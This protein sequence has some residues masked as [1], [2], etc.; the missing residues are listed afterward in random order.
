MPQ[1]GIMHLGQRRLFSYLVVACLCASAACQKSYDSVTLRLPEN[2]DN[3]YAQGILKKDWKS[4]EKLSEQNPDAFVQLIHLQSL[5]EQ[6]KFADVLKLPT[7]EDKRFKSYSVYLRNLAARELKNWEV[8]I[9]S[10]TPNDLPESLQEKIIFMK[11]T[12]YEAVDRPDEGKKIYATMIQNFPRG[13]L[14]SDALNHLAAIESKSENLSKALSYYEELYTTY[15]FHSEDHLT[16]QILIQNGRLATISI[17][18][19]LQRVTQLKKS[20]LFPRARREIEFIRRTILSPNDSSALQKLQLA[21]AQVQFSDKK[22]SLVE[23]ISRAA[24]KTPLNL[25][26]E[27]E[28]RQ[29][30]ASALIRQDKGE[31]GIAEYEKL[32]QK[33][34]APSLRE[35]I[36]YRMGMSH[37]DDGFYD[38]ASD[39]F[40]E[41]RDMPSST[42]Y[43][44]SAHWFG[45]WSLIQ[46]LK[47]KPDQ[48]A[49]RTEA[50]TLLSR[51]PHLPD[52][53]PFTPQALFWESVM[54]TDPVLK[55]QKLEELRDHWP[56]SFY[57]QLAKAKP[58]HFLSLNFDIK[59]KSELVSDSS[60]EIPSSISD[61]ISWQRLELFRAVNLKS[62]AKLELDEF[63]STYRRKSK[64]TLLVVAKR[65][66]H[67]EAWDIL[68]RWA[69]KYIPLSLNEIRLDDPDVQFHY[70]RAYENEVLKAAKE[71]QI[72][73]FLI[74]GVMREESR[75]QADIVSWAGAIGLMQLMPF[76]GQKIAKILG[77]QLGGTDGLYNPRKNIRLGAYHIKEIEHQVNSLPVADSLKPILQI[78]VYNA[79]LDAV[80]R[81]IQDKD[82]SKPE[83]FVE[84]IPYGETRQYVKRVLQS[85]HIYYLLYQKTI[86]GDAINETHG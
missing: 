37:L 16:K 41:I 60:E 56:L 19:H 80:K 31:A 43:V 39:N 85:S 23:K 48:S 78:A 71:F 14:R 10:D 53:E 6:K 83:L 36:Y 74:W 2:R 73:P 64:E 77:E 66:M 63:L 81:W 27:I 72:S 35:A 45:A 22:Y 51:L 8:V 61:N 50:L 20:A 28:W 82:I 55:T 24:L 49:E 32:L 21:L 25:E 15:P 12:A 33:K 84:A 13:S 17:E 30:L 46:G 29:L 75:F 67:L 4:I 57:N 69:E 38:K 76:R 58:F 79:G 70:P 47:D 42:A 5:C 26:F 86:E 7:I 65:L 59:S 68:V 9:A 52:G 40:R 18:K 44:E 11:G 54:E 1:N 62:W 34:I 3:P